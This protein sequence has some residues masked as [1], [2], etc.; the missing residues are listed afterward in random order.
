MERET[1]PVFIIFKEHLRGLFAV[2]RGLKANCSG[3]GEAVYNRRENYWKY[4]YERTNT[5]SMVSA[6]A[7]LL[8]SPAPEEVS[9]SGNSEYS[10]T[11]VTA[12]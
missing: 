11:D 6:R 12:G 8:R 2:G 9:E 1:V 10:Y 5:G 4:S 7:F 3:G